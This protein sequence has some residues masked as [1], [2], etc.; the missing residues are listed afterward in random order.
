MR[1]SLSAHRPA[2]SSRRMWK[3]VYCVL[4]CFPDKEVL[5]AAT[6]VVGLLVSILTILELSDTRNVTTDAAFVYI[7]QSD[8]FELTGY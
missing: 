7:L 1:F 8:R 4:R 5:L 2:H 3:G 6:Q